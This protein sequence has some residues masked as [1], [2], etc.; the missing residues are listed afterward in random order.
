MPK[1]ALKRSL[2]IALTAVSLAVQTTLSHAQ[3]ISILRDA[4]IEKF[5]EDYTFP[6]LESAG[7]NPDAVDLYLVGD[8]SPNAFVAGGLN[9]FIHSGLITLAD[10][11]NQI[12]GVIAH[13]TGHMTGGHIARS[14]D[15]A[16]AASTPM[17]LSLVLAAGAVAAGA[18]EAGIGLLGLGQN[19][20]LANYLSYSRG[21]E[22]SADQAALTFLEAQGH[23]GKGLIEFFAKL[24]NTQLITGRRY[25]PYLQTHPLANQRITA[26]SERASRSEFFD[27]ADPPE[28]IERLN[29]IKA[30]IRGFLQDTHATLRQYPLS[31]QSDAAHYARAVAYYRG[32]ELEKAQREITTL[33]EKYPD[34]PYYHELEGQMLFEFGRLAESIGPHRRSVTLAPDEPL[35]RINLGRALIATEEPAAYEE[36]VVEIKRA[37]LLEPDN[38]FGWFEI[39]RAYGGLGNDAMADL[40]TAESRYHSGA[41]GEANRFARRALAGLSKGTPE[42]RQAVDVIYATQPSTGSAAPLPGSAGETSG[43]APS[44]KSED[45]VPDPT[46][47]WSAGR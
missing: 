7:I 34:N 11:P 47:N 5:I 37:L 26:L 20:G 45:D 2:L 8:Q 22:S 38:G 9:M 3:G 23:S 46:F 25:N 29:L 16:A 12:E 32:S 30:K 31:D 13:E 40:A 17:L 39:A 19:I 44:P 18:P 33:T 24:R 1:R 28:E 10:T 41:K 21:Q 36:A 15:V 35:F 4:E 43:P 6:I 42:W 14:D 27:V